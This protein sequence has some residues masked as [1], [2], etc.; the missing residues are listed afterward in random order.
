MVKQIWPPMWTYWS[1]L[2][3]RLRTSRLVLLK[4]GHTLPSFC[5]SPSVIRGPHGSSYCRRT[6]TVCTVSDC[7]CKDWSN[8][9]RIEQKSYKKRYVV[10]PIR[11]TRACNG[12][13][14]VGWHL[15]QLMPNSRPSVAC[16]S[17]PCPPVQWFIYWPVYVYN[18]IHEVGL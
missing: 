4:V 2:P 3:I 17:K 5:N 8:L 11:R 14:H 10:G 16:L 1:S 15:Y 18:W 13:R 7:T 6:G 9:F 12:V